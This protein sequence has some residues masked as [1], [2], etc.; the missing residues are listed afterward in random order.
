MII[1]EFDK[2]L[3]K[4]NQTSLKNIKKYICYSFIYTL[5]VIT[6]ERLTLGSN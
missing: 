1:C 4:K 2:L 3:S 6:Q 5:A